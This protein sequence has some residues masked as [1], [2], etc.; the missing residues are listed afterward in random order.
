MKTLTHKIFLIAAVAISIFFTGAASTALAG[1]VPPPAGL[2]HWWRGDGSTMDRLSTASGTANNVS[3]VAGQAGSAFQFNGLDSGIIFGPEIANFRTN[4]FTM[5]FWIQTT[6][7]RPKEALLEKRGSCDAV[8][9]FFGFLVG[10]GPGGTGCLNFGMQG[11]GSLSMVDFTLTNR[12]N[13]GIY[14]YVAVTRQMGLV[15]MYLD[16]RLYA[17]TNT[18]GTTN[19]IHHGVPIP[20]SLNYTIT[21]ITPDAVDINTAA[22]LQIGQS[23][24]T[25]CDGTVPFSGSLDEFRLFNR[26]LTAAEIADWYHTNLTEL[27]EDFPPSVVTQPVDQTVFVGDYASFNAT[28]AGTPPFTY[29]WRLNDRDIASGTDSL[30]LSRVQTTDAGTYTLRITNAFGSTATRDAVLTVIDNPPC[31]PAAAGLV[32]WWKGEGNSLDE[33]GG[34]NGASIG[35]VSYQPAYVGQGIGFGGNGSM[36]SLG[37][38]ANLQLQKFTIEAWV[39]RSSDTQGGIIFGWGSGGFALGITDD[40]HL[41]SP[42]ISYKS[43]HA[44]TDTNSFHLVAMSKSS[45]TM[46][47]YIDASASGFPPVSPTYTFNT[48]A[49]IGAQGDGT[50]SFPGVIDELAIYNRDL[51]LSGEMYNIWAPRGGGVCSVSAPPT[52]ATQPSSQTVA[53]GDPVFFGVNPAGTAPFTYQWSVNGSDI[54]DATN[55]TLVLSNIQPGDPA[56]Y[57]V[58]VANALGSTTSSN[59]VLTVGSANPPCVNRPAGLVSWWSAEGN[60]TDPVGGNDGVF[61]DHSIYRDG[62]VGQAFGFDGTNWITLGNVPVNL[63]LQD[64]TIEAWIKRDDASVVATVPGGTC[65]FSTGDNGYGLGLSDDGHLV[66]SK[67]GANSINSTVQIT[68][69]VMFHHVAATKSGSTVILYVDGVPSAPINYP[70]TFQFGHVASIG[71]M[72]ADDVGHNCFLGAIDEVS[73]YNRALSAAEIQSIVGARNSGKCNDLP[74]PVLISLPMTIQGDGVTSITNGASLVL[75]RWY[76]ILATPG[77]DSTFSNWTDTAMGVT[78]NPFYMFQMQT[79]TSLTVNFPPDPVASVQVTINGNGTTSITNG[80]QLILGRWYSITATP[81]PET[82]FSS[83]LEMVGSRTNIYIRTNTCA[84]QMLPGVVLTATFV[85]APIVPLAV[86]I[87]GS[88]TASLPNG[89]KLVVGNNYTVNAQPGNNYVFSNLTDTAS[90]QTIHTPSYKFQMQNNTKLAINFAP[91]PV[92]PLPVTINGDGT[93]S[94]TNGQRLIVGKTYAITAQPK[95]NFVFSNLTDLGTGFTTNVSQCSFV[96]QTNSA[97]VI[98][99]VTNPIVAGGVAGNYNGLFSEDAGATVRSAGFIGNFTVTTNRTFSGKIF[100]QGASNSVVGKFD[101]S[102]NAQTI[103]SRPGLSALNINWHLDWGQGT[104]QITGTVANTSSS[105]PW[106]A[107]LLA[108]LNIYSASKPYGSPAKYTVVIPPCLEAPACAPHGSGYATIT[109]NNLGS[110]VLAGK[111]ADAVTFSRTGPVTKD[112]CIPVYA[113]LYS[114]QG[115]LHGWLNLSNGAPAG[116]L[117]WIRPTT[118]TDGFTNVVD[119]NGSAYTVPTGGVPAITLSNGLLEITEADGLGCPITFQAAINRTNIV[120]VGATPTNAMNGFYDPKTGVLTVKFRPTGALTNHTGFGVLLQSSN[121]AC[122]AIIGITNIGSINLH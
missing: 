99:F 51:I 81:G 109:N 90:G 29:L 2:V 12:I 26:A 94:I 55:A 17:L 47:F 58:V 67:I 101:L 57:A 77:S 102:G 20:G 120:K 115:I 73:V 43:T 118:S 121:A 34:N 22:S 95:P 13:D 25:C 19:I 88:G 60:T 35:A 70:A 39:K 117:T 112:G 86:T 31:R 105:D 4:D 40:G 68:D 106:S 5:D 9:P 110:S 78:T 27:C 76:G 16:G 69:N 89:T 7:T 91:A 108:N 79:N 10:G 85:P 23:V 97:L 122:G 3:Y 53:P 59:A 65:V 28:L 54:T 93:S 8:S 100:L 62:R 75:G 82:F 64:F 45:N 114:H 48:S 119:V 42:G 61:G 71:A 49:A 72:R 74:D 87:R 46:M 83:W 92:L 11:G 66:L 111:L 1:C 52:I 107:S 44:I 36:V 104:K 96:M 15:S 103:V 30:G 98:N 32:S 84:F 14:H 18:V 113:D 80:T 63:Q 37:S 6:S 50:L 24:C 116:R 38:P 33:V 41:Y 56:T 21:N